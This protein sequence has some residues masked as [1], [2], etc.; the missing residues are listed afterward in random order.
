[1]PLTR[2]RDEVARIVELLESD[3]YDSAD[4]LAF[5]LLK[6]SASIAL[7]RDLY[8]L[9]VGGSGGYTWGPYFTAADAHRDYTTRIKAE[10]P[11]GVRLVAIRA[12]SEPVETLDPS[13]EPTD[14]CTC[15]HPVWA[16]TRE[17]R[18]VGDCAIEACYVKPPKKRAPRCGCP[19]YLAASAE[20]E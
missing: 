20:K 1:M 4:K 10:H 12:Y 18:K 2:K 16:H 15:G 19:K 17:G 11:S 5:A 7:G 6:E 8:G 13:P 3:K 9:A 14:R